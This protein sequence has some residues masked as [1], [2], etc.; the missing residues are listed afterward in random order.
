[1]EDPQ[2]SPGFL[3]LRKK[4]LGSFPD[5]IRAL[6]EARQREDC[7]TVIN[8]LHQL[9]GSSGSYGFSELSEQCLALEKEVICSQ[10]NLQKAKQMLEVILAEMQ[11][12]YEREFEGLA[13]DSTPT[14]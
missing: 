9:A 12:I 7:D 8:L 4:Y 10:D 1:M 6:R 11:A 5:K 2:H 3:A 14:A 13:D